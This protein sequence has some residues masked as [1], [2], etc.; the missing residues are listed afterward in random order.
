MAT[1]V[2]GTVLNDAGI[3]VWLVFTITLISPLAYL[4]CSG[5]QSLEGQPSQDNSVALPR[6]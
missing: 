4:S 5:G 3:Y 1:G 2:L 6:G